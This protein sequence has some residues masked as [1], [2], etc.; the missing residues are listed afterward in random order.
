[1][2][3]FDKSISYENKCAGKNKVL[4]WRMM[5]GLFSFI[6][7]L[8][9]ILGFGYG[10]INKFSGFQLLISTSI[11]GFFGSCVV[12]ILFTYLYFTHVEKDK[13]K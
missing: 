2:K 7:I 6:F 9:L 8:S 4:F 5:T 1:M 11:S 13:K 10:W 12:A 3:V